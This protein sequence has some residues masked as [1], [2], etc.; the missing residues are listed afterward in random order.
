LKEVDREDKSL[1]EEGG[2]E[3]DADFVV[4]DKSLGIPHRPH[5][6]SGGFENPQT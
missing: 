2:L 3:F 1:R 6:S 5:L 4:E